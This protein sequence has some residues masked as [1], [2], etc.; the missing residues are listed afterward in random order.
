MAVKRALLSVSNKEGIVSLAK[1]LVE[2][3][4]EIIS[5]GG[6]KKTLEEAGVP[7]IGISD[8]TGFPE[9][10]DGRVKTLHPMIHGGLLAIRD[11]ER[12]QSELREHHITPIDLVV[13]NLYPFQQTIAK[14]DVTFAEAIE[15]IDI[16]GPTMLRAAAKNHQYV[17]VVVDPADYDTVVQEL[18][19]HGDVSAE[20]KLKLAAK[21]FRH[22]AA[23]DAMIA[24]Y[25][26]NKTGEEY[27]ESL[28]ITFEKKQALRYG[29]NPHQTAAF[30]K[31]P[32]GASFSIAQAMQ[33]H[34]KELSYN[35]INDANAALQIVK[36]FTEPAAVAVKHMNPCGVGVGATIYEAFTKA[37][38][39]DP[40]SIFG[41]I[42]ALNREVDKET[43]EK[44]H[45]I[46]LE[47]VIAPSFSKEALDILTQ[48]KNIRLLTVDFT[49]P[50]TKEKLLVSVQGGLLVQETDTHT[51]DD[52]E[53]KVVTK[54]E[55]TEQ[56]WEALRF[57]WKVVKHVKSNAIVLA[58][59]GM[60]IGIGAGQMNRVGAAKIAIEQAGEK[61]KGAVLASDA[62]FPMDDTVEAAAKAGIT[63]IIQPGGSIRDADSIKKADEYGIAMV[64]TGIRHF[65]H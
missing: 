21:V 27:P 45:E 4:V 64:F 59:D 9:I 26:T 19:K 50:N 7:V 12:H 57:A 43:A 40:T 22:T 41:G 20:T 55:P 65:K 1:Q 63:A 14:S 3:G 17:T 28:T 32:L 30:Y 51:L 15:N 62:F 37:Y 38:E 61:A 60:T 16:G 13:V 31:K 24:E 46:F 56:E 5:T 18:K 33:L 6:T 49:A 47:I 58:K 54:R 36:E 11:N 48:K 39:A 25:L 2:L 52:A 10:L 23:Y 42:I 34:G 29:E 44:M 35:N 53:I 8:V